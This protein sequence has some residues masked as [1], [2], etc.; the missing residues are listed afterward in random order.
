MALTLF[1][2]NNSLVEKKFN[3]RFCLE[4]MSPLS[5]FQLKDEIM[6]VIREIGTELHQNI[7][8]NH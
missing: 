6:C 7:N 3:D 5:I 1:S 2:R 8:E 4:I